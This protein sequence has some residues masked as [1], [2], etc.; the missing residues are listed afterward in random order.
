MLKRNKAIFSF[1][2]LVVG[3]M[4]VATIFQGCE[5]LRKKFTRQ[6]KEE[7]AQAEEPILD[8]IDYPA[9]VYDP[10]ADY[11]YRFSLF[12]IYQK[13]FSSAVDDLENKKRLKYFS[14]SAL[15][16][17]EEMQRLVTDDKKN[18]LEKAIKGFKEVSKT[19]DLPEQLFNT[20]D[21]KRQVENFAKPILA[22]YTPRKMTDNIK[23][24]KIQ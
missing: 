21:L 17:L 13:E 24:E 16:Q 19:L 14:D 3:L 8:P 11:K 7:E 1:V 9:K 10:K 4:F 23:T 22:D 15:I 5:P 20:R 18:G 2:G 6:K 12:H